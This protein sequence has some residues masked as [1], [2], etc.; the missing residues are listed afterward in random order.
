MK[1]AAS[2]VVAALLLALT[3]AGARATETQQTFWSLST[4]AIPSPYPTPTSYPVD[5]YGVLYY[6]P[7][8]PICGPAFRHRCRPPR[9]HVWPPRIPPGRHPAPGRPPQ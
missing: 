3:A 8:W 9:G 2:A 5:W 6:P 7:Y 4:G 1:A